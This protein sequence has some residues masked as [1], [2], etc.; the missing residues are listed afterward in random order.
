MARVRREPGP[1]NAEE[2]FAPRHKDLFP[3]D[4]SD[5]LG[6]ILA[7]VG[8]VLAAGGGIGGGG[9]LVPIYVMI[10]GFSP[11]L[12]VALSN[13]T[14]LGGA[15]ANMALNCSKRHPKTDRPLVDWD[16]ILIM[17]P[18]TIG[19]ALIGSFLNK[20]L[21]ER[22]MV[23]ALVALLAATAWRTLSCGVAVYH[24]ES[25]AHAK[26]TAAERLPLTAESAPLVVLLTAFFL[27]T[28]AL[29]LLKGGG[30]VRSP[31]G[32]TCSSPAFWALVA[33]TLGWV[34]LFSVVARYYLV[35]RQRVKAACGYQYCEGD[36]EWT[37]RHA[38][39]FPALCF[40]AGLFAG[41]FGVGGGIIKGPLMLEMGVLPQVASATSACMILYTSFTATTSFLAFGLLRRDYGTLLLVVGLLA[42]AVGQLL[43]SHLVKRYQRSSLII[44]IIGG[45]VAIS[46]VLLATTSIEDLLGHGAT[47]RASGGFCGREDQ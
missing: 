36:V 3:F 30:G 2:A 23:F 39:V 1:S 7:I 18:P 43:V 32:F 5:W 33:G 37:P 46:T 17:E 26:A 14:I 9:I 24:K 27:V 41:L 12:A 45:V 47:S 40:F 34:V 11:K 38:T 21:P 10:L 20:I 44:L 25:L 31:L 8:L 13:V 22:I 28:L 6:L 4:A 19:G 16:L 29:N 42:T 15:M 35:S